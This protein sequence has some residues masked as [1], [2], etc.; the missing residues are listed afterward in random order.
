MMRIE[1]DKF[2]QYPKG[3][4]MLKVFQREILKRKCNKLLEDHHYEQAIE[5]SS[6][7]VSTFPKDP[8]F[9]IYKIWALTELKQLDVALESVEKALEQFQNH[10]VL[11]N[12]KG[13][14]QF[15]MGQ[16]DDALGNLKTVYQEAPDNLHTSYILGQIYAAKGDLDQ[17]SK[18]LENILQ[19][20][21]KLLQVRLLAMAERYIYELNQKI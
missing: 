3:I 14:I 19:Y 1:Q 4:T 20:D 8:H 13:E 9:Q 18:Y 7:G 2:I 11:L 6:E 15:K 16:L 17:S 5:K 12:L 10:H 21:P